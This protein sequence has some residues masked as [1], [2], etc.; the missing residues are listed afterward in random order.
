MTVTDGDNFRRHIEP[1]RFLDFGSPVVKDFVRAAM[2][3]A[4]TDLD[5]AV[6]LY[7][8]VRDG[9]V[10]VITPSPCE[11]FIHYTSPV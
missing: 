5:K 9:M 11:T 6:N 10:W 3:G 1:T 8:A 2:R 4:A 7:Y